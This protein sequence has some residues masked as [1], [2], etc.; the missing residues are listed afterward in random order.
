MTHRTRLIRAA[1]AAV[2]AG[3]LLGPLGGADAA[4]AR[5]PDDAVVVAVI[6]GSFSPYHWDFAASKLPQH[7]NRDP[8]DDIPLS[9]APHTYLPGFP[10][11]KSF[12]RYSPLKLTL[13]P[14]EEDAVPADLD[15][16]DADAWASF[17]TSTKSKIDYRW[18]PNS[19]IIGALTFGG[20]SKAPGTRFHANT[21]AHGMGTS[22]VSVGNLYGTCPECL[23]VMI[24]YSDAPSGEEA[25]QWAQSQPWIDVVTNSYGFS[26]VERE[27][28]YNGSDVVA[29]QRATER[30]QMNLFSSGNGVSNTFTIPNSTL[31]SSQEGPDWIVTVGAVDPDDDDNY[32]GTG[33]PADIAG[34]GSGYPSA[35][36]AK[37]QSGGAAFGGTSN[38]TPTI[39]GTYARALYYARR[40]M[41]GRSR[42]QRDGVISVGKATCG[43]ARRDCEI[44]NGKLSELELRRRLFQGAIPTKGN[45]DP[46]SQSVASGPSAGD[47]RFM[48]EG[49]GVYHGRVK[50]DDA[51]WNAEFRSRLLDPLLGRVPAPKRPVGELRYM[52]A[53]SWCRQSI[54]G[55]WTK[56]YYR[57]DD[58]PVPEQDPAFP[59]RSAYQS[60]CEHLEQPPPER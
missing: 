29:Q 44:G 33:K 54:W 51:I 31:T 55:E 23:V 38:A 17:E 27:R 30:G 11:P 57:G 1:L 8:L 24:Q 37:D 43:K 16:E 45:I 22:S 12:A 59:A 60:Y 2:V 19:K 14:N 9:K 42:I 46:G 53:D 39:A 47:A 35:Y 48:S 18:I 3:A 26:Q 25:I 34:I 50:R 56:G 20:A 6:D 4:P 32:T 40:A 21:G 58:T 5:G 52:R 13:A 7:L 10:S 15:T 36:N 41:A 49:H 28:V